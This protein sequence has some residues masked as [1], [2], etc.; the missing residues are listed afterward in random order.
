MFTQVFKD[1]SIK[2]DRKIIKHLL[3]TLHSYLPDRLAWKRWQLVTEHVSRSNGH[4]T[5]LRRVVDRILSKSTPPKM[6][7]L[8]TVAS[9]LP[10]ILE[11]I[12]TEL[13]GVHSSRESELV[14]PYIHIIDEITRGYL[15]K[16]SWDELFL[17]EFRCIASE[18]SRIRKFSVR[19]DDTQFPDGEILLRGLLDRIEGFKDQHDAPYDAKPELSFALDLQY[20]PHLQE[21]ASVVNKERL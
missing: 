4:I 7:K 13:A 19:L 16:K 17:L 3:I 2:E 9:P 12:L 18:I 10:G 20:L 15:E 21:Y 8:E 1:T 5:V 6:G 11:K 14:V